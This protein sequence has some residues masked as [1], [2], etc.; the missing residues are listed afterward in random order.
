[1]PRLTLQD[2]TYKSSELGKLKCQSQDKGCPWEESWKG[3]RRGVLRLKSGCP[4]CQ[5]GVVRAGGP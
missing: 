4:P 2:S 5:E 3:G 1:M